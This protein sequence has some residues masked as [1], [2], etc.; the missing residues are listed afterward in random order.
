MIWD[1]IVNIQEPELV[2]IQQR[3]QKQT[4]YTQEWGKNKNPII[5]SWYHNT[6]SHTASGVQKGLCFQGYISLNGVFKFSK[7]K[8]KPSVLVPAPVAID[9]Q[10]T[11]QDG[12]STR[13]NI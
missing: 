6:S 5:S 8:K 9:T 13:R 3:A 2:Y 4:S 12:D 10:R 7:K 1:Q 11:L